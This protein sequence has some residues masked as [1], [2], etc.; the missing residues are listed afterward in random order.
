[1]LERN[2]LAVIVQVF[3]HVNQR[4]VAAIHS[5]LINPPR[6]NRELIDR[7]HGQN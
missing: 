6:Q 5:L 7:P 1:M 4:H 2:P 3:I